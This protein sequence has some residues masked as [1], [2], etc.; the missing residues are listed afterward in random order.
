VFPT[1]SSRPRSCIDN[2]L[3]LMRAASDARIAGREIHSFPV[4]IT[5]LELSDSE[6]SRGALAAFSVVLPNPAARSA[7]K[8]H[9]LRSKNDK[10]KQ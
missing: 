1:T 7:R 2:T 5:S 9:T 6:N 8:R 4:A 10:R 3:K